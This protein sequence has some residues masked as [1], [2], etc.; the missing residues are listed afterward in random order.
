MYT[1]PGK[2]LK[3]ITINRPGNGARTMT[4][5]R[6]CFR[7]NMSASTVPAVEN[8]T[9]SFHEMGKGCHLYLDWE[10]TRAAVEISREVVRLSGFQTS[11]VVP[12]VQPTGIFYCMLPTNSTSQFPPGH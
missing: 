9:I 2:R 1:I 3:L 5:S 4:R 8:F 7:A 12:V 6:T 11:L 10:T